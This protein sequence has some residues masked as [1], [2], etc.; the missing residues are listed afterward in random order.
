MTHSGAF[1]ES[2][3]LCY[4]VSSFASGDLTKIAISG[5][6]NQPDDTLQIECPENISTYT[7]INECTAD[8]SNSLNIK[9]IAGTLAS[10]TWEME[11]AT[12]DASRRSG[13]NQIGNY[14]FNEGTTVV[15]YTAKDQ[16]GN[17]TACSFTVIVSDNQVPKLLSAP[18]DITAD[19]IE[20]D[21]GA[22]VSWPEPE[23]VD[24]CTPSYQIL[25][26]SSH[27]SGSF[28]PIGTTK[29]T[30][31]IDDGMATTKVSYSFTVTVNDK[32]APVLTA[33]EPI[34]IAC[35]EKI[36]NLYP[37][38]REFTAA[39]GTATDNCTPVPATFKFVDQSQS[40]TVC[41]YTLT[42]TYSIAD[43][44]GNIGKVEQLIFVGKSTETQSEPLTE[45]VLQETLT[46]KS[47]MGI[48]YASSLTFNSSGTFT[49]PAGVTSITVQAFGGGGGGGTFGGRN[50]AGGG[51][52][53]YA[54]SI[55][56]V[57]PGTSY[58]VTVGPGGGPGVNGGNS[59][60]NTNL[61]VA[62]GGSSNTMSLVG[63]AG[64]TVAVSS[65]NTRYA[66]GAGGTASGNN[67]QGGGGGG[68]SAFTNA[69][70]NT[71][72][73][74]NSAAGG[75]GGTG[76]G[77]GGNG[78]ANG[79]N[80]SIGNTPGGGGG[81]RGEGGATSGTGANG[82]VIISYDCP[83]YSLT[84]IIVT[85][86]CVSSGISAVTLNSSAAGLPSGNYTVTYNRSLPVASG[87]TASV[88]VVNA[89]TA[90]FNISGLTSVGNS[91]ITIT[92]L[93]SG[94]CDSNISSGNTA[95]V[96][97]N[98]LPQGSISANGPFCASGNGQLTWTSTAGTG[99]FAIVYNDGT[100]NQ[101]ANNVV[102]GTPFS[103][104]TTP[105]TFTTTY[106]LVSVTDANGCSRNSSFT[107]NTATITVNPLP[108]ATITGTTSVC[109]NSASP[110]ITFT[111]ANGTIPYLFTY[112]INGGS[113]QTVITTSGNSV[114]I[115]APTNSE[116][117]FIYSLVSA[118]DAK[119][120]SQLQAGSATVTV[121]QLPV[122]TIHPVT[123]RDCENRIVTFNISVSGPVTSYT[124]QRKKPADAGF[125]NIPV[126]T[127]ITYPI[128]GQI[129]IDNVGGNNNPHLSQY[130][131][132]VTNG[133]C[134]VFSNPATLE[135]NEITS[136]TPIAT[137][138]TQCF[139]TN[140]S[141]TV[142]TTY[143]PL[144][145]QWKKLVGAIWTDIA[146]GGAYSGTQTA[147]LNIIGG[148]PVESGAYRVYMTF[149][150]SGADCNVN[151]TGR[152]RQITFLQQL[153][154]P[155]VANA[156]S[157][158][159]NHIPAQLSATS[160]TGGS[161][162]T[163]SYQWERSTDNT[164]WNIVA[165]AIAL[166]YQPP[167][168]TVS[169]Y[170]RIKATDSG[171]FNCGT[172]TSQSIL[173]TVN[174][175]PNISASPLSQEICPGGTITPIVISDLN[176]IPGTTFS[177]SRNNTVNLPGT[178]TLVGGN[179]L[180]GTLN[181]TTPGSLQAT[182][183]TI[184]A[185]TPAGC[186]DVKT[187]SVTVGDVIAPTFTS[188]PSNIPAFTSGASCTQAVVTPDPVFSD[189]CSMSKLTWAMTGQ[190]I[191]NSAATGI[192]TVGTYIFNSGLTTVTY[193]ATDAGDRTAT[194]SFMVTVTDNVAPVISCP[195]DKMV[196]NN[197]G[198][199]YASAATVSTGTAT[200]T[201]NC[202]PSPTI[203]GVRSDGL[204]LNANYPVGVTT[205]TWTASDG[206]N[207]SSCLQ[208]ITVVDNQAPTFTVPA[209]VTIY[210]DASCNVNKL[211]GIT[212]NVS[213]LNDNCT[214]TASLVVNYS[215]GSN[216]PGTC[217]G[218]YG[219]VRTW[220]VSDA[221][222]NTT[223]KTQTI[224][225]ADNV[226]PV[227]TLPPTK[228][229][230]C[231]A[232]NL[233]ANTGQ[234]TATDNCTPA[235]SISIT[236]TDAITPGICDT[237]YTISRTWKAIDACGNESSGVQTIN[238][239][240]AEGP[241]VTMP[242][243]SVACPSN[244]STTNKPYTTIAEFIAD[245]GTAID[246]CGAVTIEI[247]FQDEISHGLADKPGYC[248]DRVD[249]IY[250]FTDPCGNHV[251]VIQTVNVLGECG[252]S[253]CSGVNFHWVDFLNRPYADTIFYNVERNGK[254]CAD[255]VWLNGNVNCVSFNVRIDDDAVGVQ[256]TFEHGATPDVKDWRIDCEEVT[257]QPGNI[258]CL[259]SGGF[260][261]FTY[262]KQG[263]NKNDISFRSVPGIIV[264][265][266]LT[267]RVDCQ[268]QINTD[269]TFTN[270]VWTSISPGPIGAW[271]QFL[272][273]PL[274][275]VPG[276]GVNV[277]DPIFIAGVGA[278]AEI[279]YKI[280]A[281]LGVS[282][283]NQFGSNC[284]T[285]TVY[286]KDPVDIELNITPPKVCINDPLTLI[287]D[288]SP[289]S[290]Y[291]TWEWH[292][293]TGATG[294]LI[295][296]A[297]G[298]TVSFSPPISFGWYSVKVTDHDPTGIMCNSD[299]FDFQIDL[300]ISN[301]L[302]FSP[303]SGDL[304]IECNAPT[305][306]Q[307]IQ[308][309]LSTAT[310]TDD[311]G[312]VLPVTNNFI[313]IT[314]ACGTVLPVIFTAE[315][316]C[317]NI[318]TATANIHITDVVP[319]VF[320]PE[321]SN[322]SSDCSTLDP[323]NNPDYIAWLA[324]HGGATATDLCDPLLDW[325]DN[326]ATQ[327]WFGTPANQQI[328]ITFIVTDD[329][330]N[331]S[332]T[333]ATYLIIDDEP[334][335]I[336]CPVGPFTETATLNNCSKTL[337]SLTNPTIDDDCSV[338]QLTYT[339][340]GATTGSGNNTVTGVAFNVGVTTVTYTVT[341][342]AGL[343]A[344]CEFTVTIID[345]NPPVFTA[346]C[347]ANVGPVPA[348][349]GLCT[350]AINIPVPAISD[351][352]N[353]GFTV[354]N[355][356]NNTGNASGVYPVGITSVIWTITDASGNVTTCMQTVIVEDEQD[357][358]ITC[359]VSTNVAEPDLFEDFVSGNGCIWTPATVPNPTFADN[360]GVVAVTYTLSGATVG[361][362]P[363]TGFNYIN[364][365]LLNLGITTVTYTS[366][367]AAGNRSV[368]CSI[369][370]WIKNIDQPR[371]TVTCP[372]GAEQNIIVS[373]EPGICEA[374]VTVPAPEVDNFCNE[375]MNITYNGLVIPNL[376]DVVAIF[377]MGVHNIT[378]VITSASGTDFTCTQTVRVEDEQDP[379]IT[380]PV[381]PIT[382]LQVFI[383]QA[384]PNQNY[385]TNVPVELPTNYGD[386]CD[387]VLT[388]TMTGATT[389]ASTNTTGEDFV[390]TPYPQFNL[391]TT[392]ITY[393]ITDP[394]NNSAQCSFDIIVRGIPEI[395]CPADITDETDP[396]VCTKELDP[397]IP[398]L[399]L[400]SPPADEWRWVMTGATTGSG[401]NIG[402]LPT[403][404]GLFAFE[405]GETT[406]TWTA[407]NISGCTTCTQTIEITDNEKP[408]F[409]AD[410]FDACVENLMDVTYT[411]VADI[412]I[413]NIYYPDHDYYI[414]RIGSHE[415]DIDMTTYSDNCCLPIDNSGIRWEIDFEG[416]AANE[417][418]ILGTGQPSDHASV[419]NL[420]G[421][422]VNFLP[423]THTITYW[424]TDC[425]GIESDPVTADITINPRP[426]VEK[427]QNMKREVEMG[428]TKVGSRK[429][430]EAL[431]IA[432]RFIGRTE[433]ANFSGLQPHIIEMWL[434]PTFLFIGNKEIQQ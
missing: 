190:T 367:D 278:P 85:N 43:V 252:C 280:C 23:V 247:L 205:I 299:I 193:T 26:T 217:I 415:L 376:N 378:W 55:I 434:K 335:T 235:G 78:G 215:D 426:K 121:D 68:G 384:D 236:Y 63:G 9:V 228:T 5:S 31:I 414:M 91:L 103:T 423:R 82:R 377:P 408:T 186:T 319:P 176:N 29:V 373:A 216:I 227:L 325:T 430:S 404:I 391:G 331:N 225:V 200:A 148:T 45:P 156:Q 372:T 219:F 206:S 237:R 3:S 154:P 167:A 153:Q 417:P 73:P 133:A 393:I 179:T 61:V 202:N 1:S 427:L 129:R 342:A 328:T 371:F 357:P 181:S 197:P 370:V 183:I 258:I 207:T 233:P 401:S 412:L 188:C 223:S 72:G 397:G 380:C 308:D 75:A 338:P 333:T 251:D 11:G 38:L 143:P 88:T 386:N 144:T 229:I 336:T 168:L 35:N 97:V 58:P 394:S 263:S 317:H 134:S 420:W 130:R 32:T 432:V 169:T 277:S 304:Y 424:I 112:N 13:I 411:G 306:A 284:D 195:T 150:A 196:N 302:V 224:S 323:N 102:S 199:C 114:T 364:G 425:H 111:G 309:W 165:G 416:A 146:D 212:G 40:S 310:A 368:P 7:D 407:C 113:N 173:I 120:C 149:T 410:D 87:L 256:I 312:T 16:A 220:T 260:H 419:I 239:T 369:R 83:D 428:M 131:V 27:V 288:V 99:P 293:G 296:G 279:K 76:T 46:L 84:S 315:D 250:R 128:P 303:P 175:L 213:A 136:L 272:Y 334:P 166:N 187:V 20:N 405:L 49:V 281:T 106:S 398:V 123:I 403:P 80:G 355:S 90:S 54:S 189:N 341:D 381:D 203:T 108:T 353:E 418:T 359:P 19:A 354:V 47:G 117:T 313:G 387:Y 324:N 10:L 295:P 59:S 266:D 185:T 81:G 349:Q 110:N 234:A 211:P 285:V 249:R 4:T 77:T 159:Y 259:P 344:S 155:T 162:T 413:F 314:H 388:W 363:A 362:S 360:C 107:V 244:L 109:Q 245:G 289:A 375:I 337:I 12:D 330:G 2:A 297:S 326:S 71:G 298:N 257:L 347:P 145:Y 30:Y 262:C 127:D 48:Q 152:N 36:P 351:P 267:T 286:V 191:A 65:G 151:S 74:G 274:T 57:T 208:T 222:G 174:P 343:S 383:F 421:D 339:L 254:C 52:G 265:D 140:Y 268:G 291:Y 138:V 147:Q 389:D 160:A 322:G 332:Q 98:P 210:T 395:D 283:C 273:N 86:T 157:I 282:V 79:G 94:T 44:F 17:V 366:W 158:C 356:F 96:V 177:W 301:A 400:N 105:V 218:N 242:V 69:N 8:I 269:G 243:L 214:A 126:E 431:S 122:I 93:T 230:A 379:T 198:F 51:G 172:V 118:S 358:T 170:Y 101:T 246:A 433:A 311:D 264:S 135:V 180:T 21:C 232:S 275:M 66:G 89:G 132:I 422:G 406:I 15:T 365:A 139:G 382:G 255:S 6:Q 37:T 14:V 67:N 56:S 287:A 204:A 300:D 192:N 194:C 292:V 402:A 137:T 352:C 318:G 70:G 33:P 28:F 321:A 50:R 116:G 60:F 241:V 320:L 231:N 327:T 124:W 53:A 92:N 374:T 22:Y 348:D 141:Y 62:A 104:F 184:T 64:G 345:I 161:G 226:K 209:D 390:P 346:G 125:I 238:V 396:G 95:T 142:N 164:N 409:T 316:D 42:R 41:P 392:T 253:P 261:M 305:A 119:G 201:D 25:K 24:N 115:A 248:P 329:C 271:N 307:D 240:D 100:A 399:K 276:S 350:A 163:Y 340:S 221:V 39:G 429:I 18:K 270:P 182:T 294:P 361:S 34:S 385:A 171:A 178:L 290:D